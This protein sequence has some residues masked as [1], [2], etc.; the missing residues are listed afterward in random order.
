MLICLDGENYPT[1][2]PILGVFKCTETHHV[3]VL[4]DND[5]AQDV[6]VRTNWRI[7]TVI[8]SQSGISKHGRLRYGF[9]EKCREREVKGPEVICLSR[10]E[11]RIS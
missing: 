7:K 9:N 10:S 11:P 6:M 2:I 5:R 1:S 4:Q 8:S 3:L